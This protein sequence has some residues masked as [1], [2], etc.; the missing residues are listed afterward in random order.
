M[1]MTIQDVLAA[2]Q[3]LQVAMGEPMGTGQRGVKENVLAAIV[4]L[5]EVLAEINWKPWKPTR[6]DIDRQALLVEMTDVLQFWANMINCME[7]T[8]DEVALA[9]AQKW[10]ENRRRVTR[11][12][13]TRG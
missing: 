3:N 5:T 10:T 12:E 6:D 8:A 4:E 7:F 13:V 11:G 9:L 1:S 2:Q